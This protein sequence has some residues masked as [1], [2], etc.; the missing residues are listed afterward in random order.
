MELARAVASGPRVLL[1]DE[2]AAG[3]APSL[4]PALALSIRQAAASGAGVVVVEHTPS[5]MLQVASRIVRLREGKV[6]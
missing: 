2:P 5:L 6:V 1:L 4:L 3:L